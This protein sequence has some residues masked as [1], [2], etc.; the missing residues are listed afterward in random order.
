[1]LYVV[2][3]ANGEPYETYRRINTKT[4]YW[5]GKVDKVIEYSSEDIPDEY[6]TKH[7][8]IFNYQRGAGLWLWKP[9]LINKAFSKIEYGDWLMYLDSGTTVLR[10]IH[11]LT[12]FMEEK[13]QDLFLME[14]P[15]LCRQFTKRE[16]YE[17][18]EVEDNGENQLLGLLLIKKTEKT[19]S[20]IKEWLH[21]CEREELLSPKKFYPDILEFPDYYEHRED[22]SILT[23]LCIK[24]HLPAYRDCS[25]Y[26]KF[27][28]QYRGTGQW[29]YNPKKYLNCN[30]P[31]IILCNRK[32]HPLVYLLK[33]IIKSVL[34]KFKLLDRN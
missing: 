2:N 24:Y 27:P 11:I 19:M 26:G 4:S 28:F 25:D 34:H 17:L 16:C 29:L 9:F 30:Y 13:K 33:F 21:S 6:R 23:L 8:S 5:F 18:M 22:Q 7:Q 32:I 20:F 1:M 15:L 10:D 14:Q 12:Q 3:Y 31:T